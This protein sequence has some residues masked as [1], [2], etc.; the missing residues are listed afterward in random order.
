MSSPYCTL[1]LDTSV[2]TRIKESIDLHIHT[3]VCTYIHLNNTQSKH[4]FLSSKIGYCPC[5]YYVELLQK[6]FKSRPVLH[7]ILGE[8]TPPLLFNSQ[9][10]NTGR[11][12]QWSQNIF[13]PGE[14]CWQSYR[15]TECFPCLFS[16]TETLCCGWLEIGRIRKF[17]RILLSC[18][19]PY[20]RSS[21]I[22]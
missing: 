18:F 19:S 22:N 2:H 11:L 10:T 21:E 13:P 14:K 7:Q 4:L 20:H 12:D 17:N 5:G 3:Y 6:M 1:A 16:R 15:F 8:L 9:V